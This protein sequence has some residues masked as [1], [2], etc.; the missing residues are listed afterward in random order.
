MSGQSAERGRR[1]L[2][3]AAFLAIF[4]TF[5]AAGL[6][7]VVVPRPEV[8][9]YEGVCRELC[10]NT[11]AGRQAVVSSLWWSPLPFLLRWPF[12]AV[13]GGEAQPFA[14]LIVS[15]CF[16]AG[17]LFLLERRLRDWPLGR[18]R[19]G[20]V[21]ALALHPGFVDAAVSGTGTTTTLCFALQAGFS[22]ARW[23]GTRRLRFLVRLGYSA[24]LLLGCHAE[25]GLWLLIA[26]ALLAIDLRL[27]TSEPAERQAAVI[28]AGLPL[29][30]AG[31]L[32]LL[33]NWLI[34]GDPLYVLRSVASAGC[35]QLAGEGTSPGVGAAAY[36]AGA[37]A[38]GVVVLQSWRREREGAYVGVLA[39][40]LLAVGLFLRAQHLLWAPST[41]L[42]AVAL[43]T[44]LALAR[45]GGET[46]SA[47][48]WRGV[49][50][51]LALALTG[52][53]WGLP[54]ADWEWQ[55]Q[56][57]RQA[58]SV[59]CALVPAQIERHV[60]DRTPYGRVFVC[61]YA[62]FN[63][64]PVIPSGSLF[65][66]DLDFDF[67]R[68]EDEYWGQDL[69]V[70]VPRPA[71]RTAMES[72]HWKYDGIHRFGSRNALHDSDW[73]DWRLFELVQAPARKP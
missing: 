67:T 38:A 48:A 62:S 8:V 65:T 57:G 3:V 23:L 13:L 9:V 30:Y 58:A 71:G 32:W 27:R 34:M 40:A 10:A 44:I 59:R 41:I 43:F 17:C 53:A 54:R 7:L 35:R 66:R 46:A 1:L 70:L 56:A 11:T 61:G 37:V 20:F 6:Q 5:L 64:Q 42:V 4:G 52:A 15:A 29:L 39:V 45:L 73:G 25:L 24:A 2:T 51:A 50:L 31:G 22:L 33:L 63:L 60:R 49:G 21:A 16:G 26:F 47:G 28:L 36:A 14:S 69:F 18:W 12:A 55:A 72:V 68:V 19:F